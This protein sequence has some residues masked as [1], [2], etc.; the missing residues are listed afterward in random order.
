MLRDVVARMLQER[1][2]MILDF[3]DA[4][5][6]LIRTKRVRLHLNGRPCT[7]VLSEG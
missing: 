7:Y 5:E 3:A 1:P 6:E 4:W 2:G